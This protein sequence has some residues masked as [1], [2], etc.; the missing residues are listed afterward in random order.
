MTR[1]SKTN[2]PS[3]DTTQADINKT[4][5]QQT[6]KHKVD[7]RKVKNQTNRQTNTGNAKS[8][9]NHSQRLNRRTS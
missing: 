1:D 9:K 3:A 6:E 2:F 7:R 4:D 8:Q 5:K